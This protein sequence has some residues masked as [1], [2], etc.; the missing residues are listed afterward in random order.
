MRIGTGEIAGTGG[1]I[2]NLIGQAKRAE[3]EARTSATR[4]VSSPTCRQIIAD[5]QASRAGTS[6]ADK[7]RKRRRAVTV[8]H[9]RQSL[10]HACR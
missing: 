3:T 5:R 8:G 4:Y 10:P 7:C 6:H 2:A 9:C 1:T